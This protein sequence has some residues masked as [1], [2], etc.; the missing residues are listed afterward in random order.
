MLGQPPHISAEPPSS[1]VFT[2]LSLDL[3][4][5]A[6]GER[7]FRRAPQQLSEEDRKTQPTPASSG[8]SISVIIPRKLVGQS[9][10]GC[11]FSQG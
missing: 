2:L 6:D 3:G 1:Q 5:R 9:Y 4:F 8:V 11:P 10:L 7:G